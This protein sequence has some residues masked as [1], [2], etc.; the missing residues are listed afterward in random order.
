VDGLDVFFH[1]FFC[2]LSVS[3]CVCVLVMFGACNLFIDTL[4]SFCR[5]GFINLK[6]T[7]MYVV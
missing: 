4:A 5:P 3:L 6:P 2:F 1:F 7:G